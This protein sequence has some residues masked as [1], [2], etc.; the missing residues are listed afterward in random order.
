MHGDQPEEIKIT[1]SIFLA[2]DRP[3]MD[4]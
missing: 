2:D 3:P 4:K 1:A